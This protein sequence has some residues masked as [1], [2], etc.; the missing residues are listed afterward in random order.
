MKHQ[1]NF[2]YFQ[3]GSFK[4]LNKVKHARLESVKHQV[5]HTEANQIFGYFQ[6]GVLIVTYCFSVNPKKQRKDLNTE[7]FT[8]NITQGNQL[9]QSGHPCSKVFTKYVGVLFGKN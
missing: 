6:K 9:N 2:G 1:L 3:K 5:S 4:T 8:T 7:H